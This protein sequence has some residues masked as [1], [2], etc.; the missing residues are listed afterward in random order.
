MFST[1]LEISSKKGEK[2]GPSGHASMPSLCLRFTLS[3]FFQWIPLMPVNRLPGK[4]L[5]GGKEPVNV[6]V[7]DGM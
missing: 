2:M 1:C 6:C 4:L 3:P 7:H 5:F